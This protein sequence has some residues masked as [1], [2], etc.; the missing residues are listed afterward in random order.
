[1]FAV[2]AFSGGSSD[3][4]KGEAGIKYSY[5]IELRDKGEYGFLLPPDNIIPT[6]TV[7]NYLN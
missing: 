4:M 6:G 3:W 5:L 7:P 2:D 1:M